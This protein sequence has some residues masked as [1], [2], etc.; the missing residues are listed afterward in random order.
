MNTPGARS[1]AA[2]ATGGAPSALPALLRDELARLDLLLQRHVDTLRV[3]GVFS[4]DPMRG[5]FIPDEQANGLLAGGAAPSLAPANTTPPPVPAAAQAD[6]DSPARTRRR[7]AHLAALRADIDRRAAMPG[8]GTGPL[9]VHALAARFGLDATARDALVMAVA[10][11]IDGRYP[12]L[13]A[14]AH[15]DVSRRR[16]S[17]ELCAALAGEALGGAMRERWSATAPLRAWELVTLDVAAGR[18]WPETAITV[19]DG[20]VTAL[21]GARPFEDAHWA[22]CA[23]L[24]AA[25]EPC[26]Q[27]ADEPLV[28]ALR[29]A[30]DLLRDEAALVEIVGVR[31]SGRRAVAQRLAAASGRALAVL[32]LTAAAHAGLDVGALAIAFVRDAVLAG[33]A[34]CFHGVEALGAP[35]LPDGLAHRLARV[36]ARARDALGVPVFVATREQAM[37]PRASG[38]HLVLRL[39]APGLEA[40]AEAWRRHSGA[41]RREAEQ[42]AATFRLPP[43][44]VAEA[45]TDARQRA[46][47]RG[48]L[49]TPLLPE[50]RRAAAAEGSA[51][52]LAR[53]AAPLRTDRPLDAL[54]LPPR[55]MGQLREVLAAVRHRA[56]VHAD[57]GFREQLGLGDGLVVLFGGPSGTGKT[58]AAQ[59][60]AHEL[61]ASLHRID[62]SAVVSKYIGE[63]EKNLATVFEAAHDASAILFFDEADALFGKRSEVKDAHDRHANIEVAY[64]LQRLE[65]H[66]GLVVLAT[67]LAGHVDDAFA[68]RLS[69]VL[70]FPAPDAALRARLWRR[71]MPPAAPCADDVDFDFLATHLEL[72]GGHIRNVVLRAAFL[73]AEGDRPISMGDLVVAAA[74]EMQKLGRL[75]ARNDFGPWYELVREAS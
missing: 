54:V 43:E 7:D 32:D 56:R 72:A 37:L 1:A 38:T 44:R 63:T 17:I 46:R 5:L 39:P 68:R 66:P 28:H 59:V 29:H 30:Q 22:G 10:P 58:L 55:T 33:A 12:T 25:H 2:R 19:A 35:A 31:G 49:G 21:L 6:A 47:L 60:L 61:G 8:L 27:P 73:A 67:N 65:E 14:Y 62:L 20:V 71:L 34:P 11:E 41:D 74:R 51:L 53:L 4:E 50:D 16:A 70:E 18:P 15:N 40:R 13:Y 3:R 75:P 36:A 45:A 48:G 9:A 64:L 26:P 69:H 42:L 52:G 24:V 57:W 23:R